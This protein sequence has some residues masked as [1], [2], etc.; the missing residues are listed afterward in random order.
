MGIKVCPPP[1]IEM[2]LI[3]RPTLRVGGGSDGPAMVFV[4]VT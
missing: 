2:G 1:L 4:K 3:D